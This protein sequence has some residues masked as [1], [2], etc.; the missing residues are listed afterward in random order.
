ML[1]FFHIFRANILQTN[2]AT[3]TSIQGKELRTWSESSNRLIVKIVTSNV[4]I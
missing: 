4:A 1:V 3:S 2:L